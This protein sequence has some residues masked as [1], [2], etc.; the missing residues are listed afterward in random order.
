MGSKTITEEHKKSYGHLSVPAGLLRLKRRSF[1]KMNSYWKQNVG[2]FCAGSKRQT[3]DWK[4]SDKPSEEEIWETIFYRKR[5]AHEWHNSKQC[6]IPHYQIEIR[7]KLYA[8]A[9]C[10]KVFCCMT[11]FGH[12]IQF[13]VS[14]FKVLCNCI[15]RYSIILHHLAPLLYVIF[16]PPKGIVRSQ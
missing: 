13:T 8:E 9:N 12:V 16:I 1:F 14:D 2:P 15:S 10:Q 11:R 7:Y 6:T 4:I 5:D 3:M